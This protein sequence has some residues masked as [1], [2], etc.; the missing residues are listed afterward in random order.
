MHVSSGYGYLDIIVLLIS[1]GCN[2]EQ[3]SN[4]GGTALHASCQL[5]HHKVIELLRPKGCNLETRTSEG[6]LSCLGY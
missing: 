1:P 6:D 5:G 2:L 4:D 3:T